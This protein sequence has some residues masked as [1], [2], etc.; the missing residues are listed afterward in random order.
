MHIPLLVPLAQTSGAHMN[1]LIMGLITGGASLLGSIF[2]S[3]TSAKNTQA[4]IQASTAQQQNQNAFTER[5]SNTAYQRASADMKDAGLNPMMMAGGAMNASTPSGSGIQAPMPQ[6]THPLANLGGNVEKAMNAAVTAKTMEKTT[7]EIANL[8]V[9]NAKLQAD[10]DLSRAHGTESTTRTKNLDVERQRL[11]N[12]L[13]ASKLEGTSARDVLS[14]NPEIRQD[15][16]RGR[17]QD[18]H[19]GG[20]VGGVLGAV[21]VSAKEAY[22]AYEKWKGGTPNFEDRFNAA[23]SR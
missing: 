6:N 1:P 4:Q 7:D 2:S 19:I 8:K 16:N 10:V 17:Y 23:F 21:S 22:K 18:K 11:E 15:I 20:S 9:L 13:P 14:M 5:M 12:L 3:D